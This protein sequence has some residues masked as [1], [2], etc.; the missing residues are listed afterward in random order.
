M[1][2]VTVEGSLGD[3]GDRERRAKE[4]I[5]A[6]L[7]EGAGQYVCPEHG[8]L[9]GAVVRVDKAGEAFEFD[10]FCCEA[11]TAVIAGSEA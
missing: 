6:A 9:N 10:G 7:T 2:N 3:E 1:F 5:A 11:A 4:M 8:P